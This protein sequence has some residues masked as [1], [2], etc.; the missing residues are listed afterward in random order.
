MDAII[1]RITE[2]NLS[3][4]KGLAIEGEIPVSEDI[5]NYLVR[6]FIEDVNE[7]AGNEQ[8]NTDENTSNLSS[9]TSF[10]IQKVIRALD[11]KNLEIKLREEQLV[12]KVT[13]RK[14]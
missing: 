4:F 8:E 14:Y 7:T 5:L 3:D 2:S 6:L 1:H 13:A 11:E 10:D 9:G 12:L